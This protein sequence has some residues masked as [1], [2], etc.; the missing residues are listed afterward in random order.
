M[1]RTRLR[2][3]L[4]TLF[5]VSFATVLHAQ[6]PTPA[7][8]Q[9][10]LQNPALLQQLRQK[11]ETSGLTPDQVRARLRAAGY[12]ESLLDAY[13]P[14]GTGTEPAVGTTDDVF[15]A[16]TQLGIADTAEVDLLRC[17]ID[18]TSLIIPDTL[19]NGTIDASQD[20]R[21][22][23]QVRNAVRASCI[24]QEDSLTRGLKK[25]P[26]DVANGNIIFGLDFFRNRS[27]QFDPN[28][29]GPV[30]ANY[31]IHPG[32][33]LVLVLTGDVEQSYSLP[34]TREGFI[35]IPQVGQVFVNNLTMAELENVLYARL[36]RVY[37]GVRRGAGATTH[38]YITP[39]RLGSNQIYVTGD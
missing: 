38:F 26:A 14:G 23:A 30:D 11:L 22:R 8:A 24:A 35:I 12:P 33:Q 36:G 6:N 28:L 17:G 25:S 32:D 10:M 7:Q 4:C 20:A 37:S 2:A 18:S 34:V 21:R 39:A 13:L 16:V 29:A 19:P 5:V 1:T 15:S 31:Q 9:Q 3:L 27:S